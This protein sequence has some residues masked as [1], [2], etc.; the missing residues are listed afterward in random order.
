MYIY[1]NAERH[2]DN[3]HNTISLYVCVSIPTSAQARRRASAS[4][5]PPLSLYPSLYVCACVYI[6]HTCSSAPAC[7]RISSTSSA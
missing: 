6:Y 7:E 1:I 3:P 5:P 2:H 4:A